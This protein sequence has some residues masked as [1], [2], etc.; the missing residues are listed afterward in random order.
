MVRVV[1]MKL[2][3]VPHCSVIHEASPP[4]R[5]NNKIQDTSQEQGEGPGILG[6]WLWAS[7]T[8]LWMRILR[9]RKGVYIRTKLFELCLLID[10]DLER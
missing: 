2:H 10:V 5:S 9:V 6:L 7:V 8:Y 3:L 1:V 4:R